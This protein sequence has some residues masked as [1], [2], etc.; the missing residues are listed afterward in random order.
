[1]RTISSLV[2]AGVNMVQALEITQKV[3]QNF[4]YKQVLTEAMASI[5]KGGTLSAVTP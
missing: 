4:Y 5:S 2:S 1:M 3:I